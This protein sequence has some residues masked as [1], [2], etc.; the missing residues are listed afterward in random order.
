MTS[1]SGRTPNFSKEENTLLAE[2][3]RE[4][5]EVKNKGYDNKTLEKKANAWEEIFQKFSSQNLPKWLNMSLR[6]QNC[7]ACKLRRLA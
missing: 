2:L 4:F 6:C 1:K 7:L 3:R 5:S